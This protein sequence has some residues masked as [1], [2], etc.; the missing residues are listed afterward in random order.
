[1]LRLDT[2]RM[3]SNVAEAVRRQVARREGEPVDADA[4][5]QGIRVSL[6]DL[7]KPSG[8]QKNDDIEKS[9]LPDGIKELLKMIRELK[10]QIAERRAELEAIA[11]DQSL[12]DET[13]T[14]RM[15]ALR[16]QLTSLQSALSSANLNLAKL[17]R[18]SDL[19]DEQAVEL[20]QLLAA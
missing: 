15:E 11:S 10:A 18:E 5:R 14:Q 20:G 1:M 4:V 19:S 3:I 7:G 8:A 9:S 12:D 17:V 13:R 16:S 6:S 2:N